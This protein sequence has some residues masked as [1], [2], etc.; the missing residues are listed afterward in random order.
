MNR[1]V[2]EK[3]RQVPERRSKWASS[4][5][6]SLQLA[7]AFH[8]HD[9]TQPRPKRSSLCRTVIVR[10]TRSPIAARECGSTSLNVRASTRS[11]GSWQ[12]SP[13]ILPATPEAN[14]RPQRCN[15]QTAPRPGYPQRTRISRAPRHQQWQLVTRAAPDAND[16]TAIQVR[17][18][19]RL[20]LYPPRP[21]RQR[22]RDAERN[23]APFGKSSCLSAQ[24]I[25]V[26]PFGLAALAGQSSRSRS[27]DPDFATCR[28]P[29]DI[30]PWI[31]FPLSS[32]A[33]ERLEGR[34]L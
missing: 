14:A 5:S 15:P 27:P 21:Q 25:S 29:C 4:A 33:R 20:A 32:A 13:A 30:P 24:I 3:K 28:T 6:A 22:D 18:F 31:S 10:A 16:L 12:R 1:H 23:C 17:H 34:R 8:R 7:V 11:L 2:A 9:S 19:P 26:A